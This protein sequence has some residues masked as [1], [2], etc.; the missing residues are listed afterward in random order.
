MLEHG[1]GYGAY[2]LFV[3]D[4][5]DSFLGHAGVFIGGV[6]MNVICFWDFFVSGPFLGRFSRFC[7]IFGGGFWEMGC[8][9]DGNL[10]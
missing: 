5:E 8:F 2:G 7:R 1:G 4:Y 10:W 9:L 6:G 3:V